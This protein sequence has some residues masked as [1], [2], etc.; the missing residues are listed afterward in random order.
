MKLLFIINT[1]NRNHYLSKLVKQ[2]NECREHNITI[3]IYD[4]HSDKEHADKNQYMVSQY[5][6]ISYQYASKNHGKKKYWKIWDGIMKDIEV[7]RPDAF[8]YYF[9]IPDD[10]I[11]TKNF[12][13]ESIRQYENIEDDKK[14]MLSLF[15]EKERV[16]NINWF[17]GQ[18]EI[19][20]FGDTHYHK[21]QWMD[22]CCIVKRNFFEAL[23]YKMKKVSEERWSEF[24]MIGSGVG[25][26]ITK[27]LNDKY[28]LY[29]VSNS[30]CYE[31]EHVS[32]MNP[33]RVTSYTIQNNRRDHSI[34]VY[35]GIAS[36]PARELLLQR[37]IQSLIYQVDLIN[38]YLNN[39]PSIPKFLEHPKINVYTSQDNRD[40]GD[41][42][43]FH[44]L[45]S[46]NIY[47]QPRGGY[48]FSCDDDLIYPGD[49]VYNMINAIE[50]NNRKAV[51][52]IHGVILNEN[53][54]DYYRNRQV[55]PCLQVNTVNTFCHILG[56]GAMAF[57]TD[58]IKLPTEWNKNM[59]DIT[60]GITAQ[61][62]KVPML[63]IKHEG[64][65]LKYMDPEETIFDQQKNDCSIQ[66]KLVN[67]LEWNIYTVEQTHK[68]T[69][70]V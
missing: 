28:S 25:A 22:M 54:K 6:N 46:P 41:G 10:F 61:K 11:L 36:I 19:K 44:I 29:H 31:E 35:V 58:T 53:V 16:N 24:D 70:R 26:Q 62:Q 14:I 67:E 38:V 3:L 5:N 7:T 39:Y 64:D 48:Y 20:Q 51:I 34:P 69:E 59:A 9:I 42:G 23:D 2:I 50:N 65:W 63:C 47:I 27:R 21:T 13:N 37:T 43:K 1:Y 60:F 32:M 40:K 52:G 33:N 12:I 49:Y 45:A 17:E 55:L 30:L 57:H 8:D 18:S 68:Q 56:T 66:T 15:I 4:D